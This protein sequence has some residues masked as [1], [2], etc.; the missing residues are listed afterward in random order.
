[1]KYISLD[2]IRNSYPL[3]KQK[4]PGIISQ[5]Y[6]TEADQTIVNQGEYPPST[7]AFPQPP[8][9]NDGAGVQAVS[10]TSFRFILEIDGVKYTSPE[11]ANDLESARE[12][13][14]PYFNTN[15]VSTIRLSSKDITTPSRDYR[16]GLS[17][18]ET[19]INPG[20]TLINGDHLSIIKYIDNLVKPVI[21]QDGDKISNVDDM[22]SWTVKISSYNPISDTGLGFEFTDVLETEKNIGSREEKK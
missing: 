17:Y 6:R 12:E 14:N 13:S 3:D 5:T 4:K 18:A 11:F 19:S 20:S 9:A 21:G 16:A 1:M 15:S 8:I 2:K 7:G 10:G 22:G